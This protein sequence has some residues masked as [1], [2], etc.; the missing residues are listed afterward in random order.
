MSVI[1][2]INGNLINLVQFLI[3]L[4]QQFS[5]DFFVERPYGPCDGWLNDRVITK[6][7]LHPG[8]IHY[9]FY[10]HYPFIK[11]LVVVLKTNNLRIGY[12]IVN[13]S[14]KCIQ[15]FNQ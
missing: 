1:Y 14:L 10:I 11:I 7:S 12:K 9:Y 15:Y 2:V 3:V 4:I 6:L 8:I 13:Q 5:D